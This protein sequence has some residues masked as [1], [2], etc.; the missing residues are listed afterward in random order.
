MLIVDILSHLHSTYLRELCGALGI[1]EGLLIAVPV[2]GRHATS[3][4]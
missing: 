3:T 2:T 1:Y 4:C